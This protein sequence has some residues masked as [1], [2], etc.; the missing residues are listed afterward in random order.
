MR[1]TNGLLATFFF[2]LALPVQ[3]QQPPV[4]QNARS[5]DGV[6]AEAARSVSSAED[7]LFAYEFSQPEF[8]V[9]R[10]TIEHDAA[11]RGKLTFERKDVDGPITEELKISPATL[12]RLRSLWAS[13]RYLETRASYQSEKQFP[14]LG[15]VRLRVRRGDGREKATEFNWTNDKDAFALANEYRRLADQTI[16][17]FDLMVARD[18]QPLATPKLMETLEMMIA[19]DGV[20]DPPQLIPF[21]RELASDERLP[22]M[23]RNKAAKLLKKLEK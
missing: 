8:Y 2:L 11:G 1:M 18:N 9:R 5:A 15:T 17:A 3:G 14:H 19:R 4:K 21:L 10:I 7:L 16:L 6:A 23:A 12:E 20:A 13:L 22:L